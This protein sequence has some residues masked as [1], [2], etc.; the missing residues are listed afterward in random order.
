MHI[1][2]DFSIIVIKNHL[3]RHLFTL[4]QRSSI[5]QNPSDSSTK[6]VLLHPSIQSPD[7]LPTVVKEFVDKHALTLVEGYKVELKYE[8]WSSGNFEFFF[9]RTMHKSQILY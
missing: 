8:D 2:L 4:P 6:L 1:I 7:A 5:V 3:I 9:L